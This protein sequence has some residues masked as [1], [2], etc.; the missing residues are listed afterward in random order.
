MA[1]LPYPDV[2][3]KG[4]P[5]NVMKQLAH[6]SATAQH[7]SSVGAAQFKSLALAPKNR[8]LVIL[9]STSK[10]RSSYEWSH[11]AVVSANE[12]VTDTQREAL[13]QAGKQKGYFQGQDKTSLFAPQE[14]LLLSFVEAVIDGPEV[15]ED[16]WAKVKAEFS[17]REIVEIITLQGF[18]Y[19]FSR[20]T[21]VLDVELDSFATPA[22]L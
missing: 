4:L 19:T 16:L 13:A 15:A 17:E 11:H 8:E 20:L 7:W 22:K 5:L 12:G 18:Y 14:G 1:R 2:Q 6:S 21:T 10:F 3:L 9:L